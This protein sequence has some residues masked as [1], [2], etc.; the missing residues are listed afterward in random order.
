MNND[1]KIAN[2]RSNVLKLIGLAFNEIHNPNLMASPKMVAE[3]LEAK[4]HTEYG[5]LANDI[6][7]E[8]SI[9]VEEA[10]ATLKSFW[11]D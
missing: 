3:Q 10:L 2:C 1:N 4:I 9:T 5:L 7:A 8:K 6:K 11:H